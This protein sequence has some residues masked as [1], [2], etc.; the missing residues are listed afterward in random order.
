MKEMFKIVGVLTSVCIICAFFLSF[1][2]STTKVKIELNAKTK[3][4]NAIA[5]LAPATS[6]IKK[7]AF[8]GG[9]LYQL[10]NNQKKLLGFAFLAQ[11][12]G[13]QGLIKILTVINP[14]LGKLEGIE[15]V[16]SV[17]TPGLGA[18]IIEEGFKSQFQNLNVSDKILCIKDDLSQNN[19]IKA[20]TGATVSSMA[21]ANILNKKIAKLREMLRSK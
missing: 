8:D 15:I 17:E 20:I 10:S 2:N 16:E 7:V 21:V 5:I 12:Q 6:S 14:S 18:K 13:Y 9:T 11:G 19:Q 3:I 1:A 4:E